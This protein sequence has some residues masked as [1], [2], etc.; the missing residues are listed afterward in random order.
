M[1]PGDVNDDDSD[2]IA[3]V[4]HDNL[5]NVII[6]MK[7]TMIKKMIG[8]R[9]LMQGADIDLEVTIKHAA[10]HQSAWRI[11]EKAPERKTKS[12]QQLCPEM[13]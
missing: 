4:Q 7:T 12:W 3:I 5:V 10:G 2:D 1:S 13:G 9:M 11:Q 6:T 8:L